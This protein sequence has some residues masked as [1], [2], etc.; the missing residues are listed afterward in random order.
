MSQ[1]GPETPAQAAPTRPAAASGTPRPALR[2]GPGPRQPPQERTGVLAVRPAPA[3][4]PAR[5]GGAD[6]PPASPEASSRALASSAAAVPEPTAARVVG[7]PARPRLRITFGWQGDAL[8]CEAAM[9]DE[10][11]RL[12]HRESFA[13]GPMLVQVFT[14][15]ASQLVQGARAAGAIIMSPPATAPSSGPSSREVQASEDAPPSSPE[16]SNADKTPTTPPS[17]PSSS[18]DGGS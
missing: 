4:T 14:W 17:S 18:S 9:L 12:V 15:F 6:G 7:L 16:A 13:A 1:R 10:S 3:G 2:D 11:K 5:P 8:T